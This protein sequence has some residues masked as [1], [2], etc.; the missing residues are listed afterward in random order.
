VEAA[1]AYGFTYT[2]EEQTAFIHERIRALV[3]YIATLQVK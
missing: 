1:E 2:P 3:H